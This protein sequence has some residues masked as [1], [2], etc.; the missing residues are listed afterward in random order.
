MLKRKPPHGAV[1]LNIIICPDKQTV[2]PKPP[3]T[4]KIIQT[5][6]TQ[7]KPCILYKNSCRHFASENVH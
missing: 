4:K 2:N 7:P 6:K 1:H 5:N 3:Q